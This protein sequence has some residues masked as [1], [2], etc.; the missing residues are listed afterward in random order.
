M[1][2]KLSELPTEDY[3]L[4]GHR[5]CAGCGAAIAI[6]LIL[7]V[8]GPNTIVAS[9]TGCIEV[10]SSLYPENAWGVPWIHTAFENAAATASGVE[11]AYKVLRR[12]GKISHDKVNFLAIAGDGGTA[13][14]GIQALSGMAERGHNVKYIC[15][16]NEA[17]MNTG[18]QRSS[19]TPYGAWTTTSPPG[20][21]IPIGKREVK[22]DVARI[23]VAHGIPYVATASI[24]YPLDLMRKVKTALEIEGPAYIHVHTPCP[25]G[26]RF[27]S[28]KTI[29]VA[30]LAVQTG[31]WVL[32]EVKQGRL[33]I[34]YKLSK[35]KPV[36]EYLRTQGRFSHL[37]DDDI[38]KIQEDVRKRFE[39]FVEG[40]RQLGVSV[41][42]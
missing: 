7:K 24:G 34:T 21:A 39:E 28:N 6:R 22:K 20:K 1:S 27:E 26:W 29:E 2:I 12:K 42:A 5:A 11:A 40:Y 25:T 10:I 8:A 13:D 30:R 14:I 23:M 32:Y 37:T 3:F 9:A 41:E 17:Y 33:R 15:Y 31:M 4:P 36:E 38:A 16:D 18:I 35:L 19:S